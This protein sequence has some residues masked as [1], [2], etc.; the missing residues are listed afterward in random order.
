MPLGEFIVYLAKDQYDTF[1][2]C[3]INWLLKAV[4]QVSGLLK[5]YFFFLNDD[6]DSLHCS[7]GIWANKK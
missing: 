4:W 5:K 6:L 2:K 1:V 3:I 7:A